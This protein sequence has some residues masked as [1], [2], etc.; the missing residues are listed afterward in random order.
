[1]RIAIT[2]NMCDSVSIVAMAVAFL[3]VFQ[4]CDVPSQMPLLTVL[5]TA[6]LSIYLVMLVR[7]QDVNNGARP[8]R[9]ADY[10]AMATSSL[11]A[12]YLMIVLHAEE[13]RAILLQ[14]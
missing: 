9:L 13:C 14:A 5:G 8:A 6:T 12:I 10:V 1:M 4:R 3:Y 2:K 11:I 7:S